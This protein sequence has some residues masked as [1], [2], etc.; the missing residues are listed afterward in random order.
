MKSK[1]RLKHLFWMIAKGSQLSI[2]NKTLFS[3]VSQ[4]AP[5][6]AHVCIYTWI[7]WQQVG[8]T[9]RQGSMTTASNSDISDTLG[10]YYPDRWNLDENA[11]LN[12][13]L[14]IATRIHYWKSSYSIPPPT[15]L[16]FSHIFN[17]TSTNIYC[18][19]KNK[20][21]FLYSKENTS[22]LAT[23]FSLPR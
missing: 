17:A 19:W 5:T 2:K 14:L 18:L 3:S 12:F 16:E 4:L 6:H 9:R 13:W 23:V 10:Q 22:F 11:S 7:Y 8:F 21:K 15:T 1:Y 20:A